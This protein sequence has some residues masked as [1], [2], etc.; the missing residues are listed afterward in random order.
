MEERLNRTQ[1]MFL[2]RDTLAAHPDWLNAC[3]EAT[4]AGIQSALASER[5]AA[6]RANSAMLAALCLT[7][8]SRMTANTRELLGKIVD[9]GICHGSNATP[10]EEEWDNRKNKLQQVP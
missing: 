8:E 5:A 10:I 7:K 1:F 4:T 2:V 9:S 6:S 3:I